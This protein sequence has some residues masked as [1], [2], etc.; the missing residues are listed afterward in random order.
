MRSGEVVGVEALIRWQHPTK[1]L[2]GPTQ[3]LPVIE[4]HPIAVDIGEWVIERS[5]MQFLAWKAEGQHLPI[6]INISA[7]QFHEGDFV[8]R[9]T[10][11]FSRYP[12]Y[13]SHQ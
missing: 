12:G 4:E 5:L 3:F 6:S 13:L 11:L 7:R 9:L 2:L 10:S 8:T 1:G